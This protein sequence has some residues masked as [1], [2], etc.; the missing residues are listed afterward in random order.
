MQR[1][2]SEIAEIPK[3]LSSTLETVSQTFDKLVPNNNQEYLVDD[4][5]SDDMLDGESYDEEEFDQHR[6]LKTKTSKETTPES[7]YESEAMYNYEEEDNYEEDDDS[8]KVEYQEDDE[9]YDD[10]DDEDVDEDDD[11][12][13]DVDYEYDD[14]ETVENLWLENN[15]PQLT[16][17]GNQLEDTSETGTGKF[18]KEATP[19]IDDLIRQE[20]QE[21]VIS[22]I[23]SY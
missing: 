15:F 1:K 4:Y 19:V 12:D 10:N 8:Y 2:L 16:L 13:D 11:D 3:I 6:S 14:D 22:S 9:N 7:D 21:K 17:N 18:L 23:F 20:K 5:Y